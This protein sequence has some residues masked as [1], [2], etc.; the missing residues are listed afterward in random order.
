[1]E[2]RLTVTQNGMESREQ[3]VHPIHILH[4]LWIPDRRGALGRE[5]EVSEGFDLTKLTPRTQAY[6]RQV[7]AF[8]F[9]FP[10]PKSPTRKSLHFEGFFLCAADRT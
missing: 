9:Q 10:I 5:A 6:T 3:E 7:H 4:W 8:Y 2:R 1:M